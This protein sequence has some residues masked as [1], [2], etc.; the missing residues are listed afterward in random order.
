MRRPD[1]SVAKQPRYAVVG[2]RIRAI[3]DNFLDEHPDTLELVSRMRVGQADNGFNVATNAAFRSQ[4][5]ELLGAP[6]SQA[7]VGLS[8][9][10]LRAWKRAT[11]E[12]HAVDVLPIWLE[13]G[14]PLGIEVL[15]PIP[16]TGVFPPVSFNEPQL[17]PRQLSSIPAGWEN[18]SSAEDEP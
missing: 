16:C 6:D 5:L 2:K 8:P 18:Y 12:A 10:V 9:D 15:E 1:V 13:H 4:C 7:T 17:A 14:A 11:Q 3:S